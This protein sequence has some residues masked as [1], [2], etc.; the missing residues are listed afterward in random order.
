MRSFNTTFWFRSFLLLALTAILPLAARSQTWQWGFSAGAGEGHALAVDSAGS[1]YVTG[2]FSG[3]VQFGNSILTTTGP[4]DF[5]GFVAKVTRHFLCLWAVPVGDVGRGLA[6]DGQG[7][8]YVTGNFAGTTRIGTS[9]FTSN[10]PLPDVFVAKLTPAG[11]VEWA[12]QAGSAGDD[13]GNAVVAD[14]GGVYVLGTHA[15]AASFGSSQ[16]PG[17][18]IARAFVA[19]LNPSGSWQWA[20]SAGNAEYGNELALDRY[21]AA[22][23]TG[24]FSNQATFGPTTLTSAGQNDVFVA[25]LTPSGA[26][27][28]AARAGGQSGDVGHGV[29]VDRDRNVYVGGLFRGPAA[30]FGTT[31]L[32]CAG[33]SD[34]FVAQ[35]DSTG[36]FRWAVGVGGTDDELITDVEAD[37]RG[38]VL[39]AGRFRS[40]PLLFGN[41]PGLLTT[42]LGTL[43]GFVAGFDAAGGWQWARSTETRGTEWCNALASRPDTLYTTGSFGSSPLVLGST[44][45]QAPP[46][47]MGMFVAQMTLAPLATPAGRA[48]QAADLY[49]NPAHGTAFL[50]E[51]AAAHTP[52]QLLDGRG[53]LLRTIPLTK[54]GRAH[55]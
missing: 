21:G 3:T 2:R 45:V 39:I 53:R 27:A 42:R 28:W 48:E 52:V 29:A 26:W 44:Y 49:P 22:Y 18:G 10:G 14:P 1:M 13:A 30:T 47:A 51:A 40:S 4:N 31:Q 7:A 23:V 34:A 19:R 54:I 43:H 15:E 35:L 33:N 38:R 12:V 55:V 36:A 9:T 17:A 37:A 32:V 46:N 11:A 20:R 6:F 8:L 16:L 50:R 5:D 25:K 41:Q 24:G